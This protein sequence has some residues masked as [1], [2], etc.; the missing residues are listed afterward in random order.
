[1]GPFIAQRLQMK[2]PKQPHFLLSQSLVEI[3]DGSSHQ[4]FQC[5]FFN[6]RQNW[7]EMKSVSLLVFDALTSVNDR[8]SLMMHKSLERK[9][10]FDNSKK[11]AQ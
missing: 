3:S 1:M 2:S 10:S 5:S 8:K 7:N 4:Q 9:K 11:I 6:H